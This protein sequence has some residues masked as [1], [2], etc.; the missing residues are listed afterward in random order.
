MAEDKV[1]RVALY[2]AGSLRAALSQITAAF[3]DTIGVEVDANVWPFRRPTRSASRLASALTSLR[4]PTWG[5]PPRSCWRREPARLSSSHALGFARAEDVQGGSFEILSQ[6]ARPLFGGRGRALPVP[7][8]RHPIVYFRAE[9]RDVDI[10]FVYCANTRS[11]LEV[12]PQLRLLPLPPELDV[13]AT[14]GLAVLSQGSVQANRLAFSILSPDGQ[15]ILARHGFEA[16][17]EVRELS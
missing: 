8:G 2:A 17:L 6:K 1:D 15:M 14:F 9:S 12:G 4:L 13:P 5:T 10:F 7:E 11:V 3:E 16:P